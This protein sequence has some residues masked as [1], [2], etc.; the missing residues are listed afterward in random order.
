MPRDVADDLGAAHGKSDQRHVI[1]I[2]GIEHRRQ[3]VA[4]VLKS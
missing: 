3:I 2:E 1:Q 4:S